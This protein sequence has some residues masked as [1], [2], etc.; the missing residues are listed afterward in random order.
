[1]SISKACTRY[2][3]ALVIITHVEVWN[4][5]A[6]PTLIPTKTTAVRIDVGCYETLGIENSVSEVIDYRSSYHWRYN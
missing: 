5:A 6:L 1:M 3:P 4:G 2:F